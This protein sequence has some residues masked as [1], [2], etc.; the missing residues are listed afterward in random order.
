MDIKWLLTETLRGCDCPVGSVEI[1]TDF[2]HARVI[3]NYFHS[4][5]SICE[6]YSDCIDVKYEKLFISE[7]VRNDR[8]FIRWKTSC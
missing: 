5:N 7:L 3:I 6:M 4:V 8:Y 2:Q 1:T